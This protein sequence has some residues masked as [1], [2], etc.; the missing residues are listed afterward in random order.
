MN[1][2]REFQL[3]VGDVVALQRDGTLHTDLGIAEW[4]EGSQPHGEYRCSANAFVVST[5]TM[6]LPAGTDDWIVRFA[7][8][9]FLPCPDRVF[10]AITRAAPEAPLPSLCSECCDPVP[11][12]ELHLLASGTRLCTDCLLEYQ[13]LLETPDLSTELDRRPAPR[14][15]P[16]EVRR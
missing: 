12:T 2:L 11:P 4:M 15:T 14:S 1:R 10:S 8:G 13:L 7:A 5:P 9:R 16:Q 3:T 6:D